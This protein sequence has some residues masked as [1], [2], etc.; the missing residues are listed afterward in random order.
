MLVLQVLVQDASQ[1]EAFVLY[2]D[3]FRCVALYCVGP[4]HAQAAATL[5]AICKAPAACQDAYQSRD[6]FSTLTE[7]TEFQDTVCWPSSVLE[8]LWA[9]CQSKDNNS[10]A[11]QSGCAL[12]R[13][14]W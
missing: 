8:F 10:E 12:L 2:H 9:A 4:Y 3:S 7:A 14:R 5:R 1:R 11:A 6:S 13:L